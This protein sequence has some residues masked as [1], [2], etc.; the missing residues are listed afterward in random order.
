MSA[1]RFAFASASMVSVKAFP[2]RDRFSGGTC[3]L[4][5]SPQILRS[6]IL[7]SLQP[8]RRGIGVVGNVAF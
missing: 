8:A 5:V 1:S 7:L 4:T 3:P 6:M 2:S